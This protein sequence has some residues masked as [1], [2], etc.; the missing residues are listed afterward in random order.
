MMTKRSLSCGKCCAR[1][2]RRAL[3][4][5]IMSPCG[6][7]TATPRVEWH[8]TRCNM[9]C[10]ASAS[11]KRDLPTPVPPKTMAW[12]ERAASGKLTTPP[13]FFSEG[14]ARILFQ[15][16]GRALL[17]VHLDPENGVFQPVNGIA[18]AVFRQLKASA[19]NGVDDI[20]RF[21]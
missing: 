20:I 5:L 11:R 1:I 7:M 6:S 4:F 19:E 18:V 12:R 9:S 21:V 14:G 10:K 2:A 13:S 16:Q 3:R 15:G 17:I 8:V